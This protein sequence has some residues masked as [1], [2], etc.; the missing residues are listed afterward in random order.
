MNGQLVEILKEA[1][2]IPGLMKKIYGDLAKP[3][4]SQVGK[5]LSSILGLGNTIL[6]PITLA[7]EKS[8]IALERNLN[9]YREQLS[10][11]PLEEIIPVVPEIGVPI[12]EKLAYIY[13]FN[14][15]ELYIN[16]LSSASSYKTS[17]LAHPSFVNLIGNISPDEAMLLPHL[18]NDI[19]FLECRRNNKSTN[20]HYYLNKM[21]T[22]LENNVPFVFPDNTVAYISNFEG[23]GLIE[24]RNNVYI[25]IPNVYENLERFYRPKYET[26]LQDRE[27]EEIVFIRG[28]ISLTSFGKL[29]IHACI[30]AS[31]SS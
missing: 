4:V 10:N 7:N 29:F 6:W 13:D 24:I 5:A 18:Q 20:T 25:K 8:R 28:G 27:N 19:P 31:A 3:G 12:A 1:I 26:E 23:L 9:N 22:G 11:I 21:L 30:K 16:L 2:Q 15:S 14:L 17:G